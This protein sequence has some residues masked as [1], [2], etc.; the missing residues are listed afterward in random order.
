MLTPPRR[1][2]CH[3]RKWVIDTHP[4][5]R[6]TTII[7]DG[8]DERLFHLYSSLTVP[9]LATWRVAV[10]LLVI[11]GTKVCSIPP[12]ELP[13]HYFW[14]KWLE[15]VPSLLE[16]YCTIISDGS[17]EWLFHLPTG[18][19]YDNLNILPPKTRS[20]ALQ[21]IKFYFVLHSIWVC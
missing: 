14:R 9:L 5:L 20:W 19:V 1:L 6:I 4:T 16:N 7:S 10:S 18:I 2:P 15:A 8:S 3:I 12:G 21:N 17:D 11:E 13:N